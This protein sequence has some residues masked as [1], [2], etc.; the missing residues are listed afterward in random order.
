MNGGMTECERCDCDPCC[1]EAI[2]KREQEQR[3]KDGKVVIESLWHTMA[4]LPSWK[5]KIIKWLW[6]DI[7][8]VA[9]DLKE[10]YWSDQNDQS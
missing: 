8:D 9:D 2:E 7:I 6:P 10:Y 5:R 4:H 1:C 3:V